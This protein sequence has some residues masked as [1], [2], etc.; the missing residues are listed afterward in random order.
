[1]SDDVA[2]SAWTV[3][4]FI[5]NLFN[6][7]EEE[8]KKRKRRKSGH[9]MA[10]EGNRTGGGGISLWREGLVGADSKVTRGNSSE[11]RVFFAASANYC[12]FVRYLRLKPESCHFVR[13]TCKTRGCKKVLHIR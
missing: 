1:M 7:G 13:N 10:I 11:E 2:I 8:R 6:S 12:I 3:H 5:S 9:V 4:N